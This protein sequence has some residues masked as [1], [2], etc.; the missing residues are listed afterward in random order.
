MSTDKRAA[1]TI[2]ELQ[3]W[4]QRVVARLSR[5]RKRLDIHS[6][7]ERLDI[8]IDRDDPRVARI[9]DEIKRRE[10]QGYAYDG[11][12]ASFELLAR[13]IM[14]QVPH[15]FSVDSYQVVEKQDGSTIATE[16]SV[17]VHSDGDTEPLWSVAGGVD[18]MDA[19]QRA[20]R[21][22]LGCY[23]RHM[24]DF[25]IADYKVRLLTR[26]DETIARVAVESRSRTTGEH[27]F[28]VGVS[29]DIVGASFEALVDAISY[30]LLKSNAETAHALAS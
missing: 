30:K 18:P 13:R 24:T 2:D 3:M 7:L 20:L 9:L 11:V 29:S 23:Q 26:A 17:R 25:E 21:R 27:W 28:T 22:A 16:A 15:Y 8:N 1:N 19:L 14:G 5:H 10:A 4:G 12:D 6:E